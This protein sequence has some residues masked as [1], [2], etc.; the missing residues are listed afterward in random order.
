MVEYE[1]LKSVDR[2]YAKDLRY[3]ARPA[4]RGLE[5]DDSANSPSKLASLKNLAKM[6]SLVNKEHPLGL[7]QARATA[8]SLSEHQP[9]RPRLYGARSYVKP[10]GREAT[11]LVDFSAKILKP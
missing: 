4:L 6:I 7:D 8:S 3:Q 5:E 1:K 9:P 10:Q 11:R 2:S